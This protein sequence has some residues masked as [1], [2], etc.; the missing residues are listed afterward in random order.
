MSTQG[1]SAHDPGG[2]SRMALVPLDHPECLDHAP[3]IPDIKLGA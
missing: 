1:S 3:N 2:P